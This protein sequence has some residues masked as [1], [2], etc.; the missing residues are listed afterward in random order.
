MSK[1]YFALLFFA[2][3]LFVSPQHLKALCDNPVIDL[4]FQS[5][6][7]VYLGINF[8]GLNLDFPIGNLRYKGEAF[9]S[10][11][12]LGYEYKKPESLYLGCHIN[13]SLSDNGFRITHQRNALKPKC[14]DPSFVGIAVQAGYNILIDS[15]LI[16]PYTGLGGWFIETDPNH[17]GVRETLCYFAY[18]VKG[19]YAFVSGY[20]AGWDLQ[21]FRTYHGRK[22]FKNEDLDTCIYFETPGAYLGLPLKAYLGSCWQWDIQCEP[23]IL[24]FSLKQHQL[25]YGIRLSTGYHF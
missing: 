19:A 8:S 21:F 14:K 17:H 12:D 22:E 18:G 23:Y 4:K 5:P 11:I 9:S 20:E 6:H 24:A 16:T 25:A 1:K 15:W 10:G 2:F 13:T 7:R 3:I